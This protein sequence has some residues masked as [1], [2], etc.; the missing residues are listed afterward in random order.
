MKNFIKNVPSQIV[1]TFTIM[2]LVLTA[3]SISLGVETIPVTRLVEF[4]LLA[5][6]GGILMEF[7]FGTC[8]IKRMA[9]VKRS[10]IFIVPF[11]IITFLCAVVFHWIT[12]LHTISTYVKFAGI[13]LGCWLLSLILFEIEHRIRGKKYTEKLREYQNEGNQRE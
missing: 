9:D 4:F 3:I 5:I 2:I 11:A 6:P 10:I 13:F 1:A 7:A 12:E 8:I